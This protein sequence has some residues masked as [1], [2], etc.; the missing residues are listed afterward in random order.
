MLMNDLTED[1]KDLCIQLLKN[2]EI[3]FSALWQNHKGKKFDEI[4]NELMADKTEKTI[5]GGSKKGR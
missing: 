2:V 3:K 5:D 4:Y 1:D